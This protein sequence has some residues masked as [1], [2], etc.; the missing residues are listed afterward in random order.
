[1]RESFEKYV[2][3]GYECLE[4]SIPNEISTEKFDMG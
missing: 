3:L 2:Y 1:M 4:G